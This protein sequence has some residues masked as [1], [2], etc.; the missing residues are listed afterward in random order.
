MNDIEWVL[1]DMHY[2]APELAAEKMAIWYAKL[3]HAKSLINKPPLG[4]NGDNGILDIDSLVGLLFSDIRDNC[5]EADQAFGKNR[6]PEM[7]VREA[8]RTT[9]EEKIYSQVNKHSYDE[10]KYQMVPRKATKEMFAAF[11]RHGRFDPHDLNTL[12]EV[13]LATAP[14]RD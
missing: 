8:M 12:W 2:C 5:Y 10:T 13:L 6:I 3:E 4:F 1:N 9:L 14:K 7:N 11:A